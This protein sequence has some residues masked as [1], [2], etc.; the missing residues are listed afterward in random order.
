MS[1]REALLAL[2]VD[3]PKHGYQLRSEFDEA[4]GATW[5]LNVGQVY[6]TL[7][8]LERDSLVEPAGQADDEGR[9][10]YVLTDA[11]QA[12][13][14]RWLHTPSGTPVALR[15]EASMRVLLSLATGAAPVLSILAS[16]RDAA[17]ETLQTLTA[18]KTEP[19]KSGASEVGDLAWRLQLDRMIFLAEAEIRWLELTETRLVEKGGPG[20]A[21]SPARRNESTGSP[22]Q[23]SNP[24]PTRTTS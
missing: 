12:E 1:V 21:T 4:T 11:G 15:D 19:P 10:S 5:A 17:M 22:E 16:Q 18:M 9:I 23:S 14:D 2:L 8:R 3:G 24:T 6:T 20:T 13:V 7:Q